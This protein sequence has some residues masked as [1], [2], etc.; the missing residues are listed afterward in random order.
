M[1]KAK[2][3]PSPDGGTRVRQLLANV[4]T[5]DPT[6]AASI[7]SV[8]ASS[9]LRVHFEDTVDILC[10]ALRNNERNNNSTRRISAL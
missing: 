10:Q 6:L 4:T 3:Y 9:T 5:R 2:D 7:A 1:N 8:R